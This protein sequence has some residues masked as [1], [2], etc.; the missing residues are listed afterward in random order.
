MNLI[1][2][3]II[4]FPSVPLL[5]LTATCSPEDAAKIDTVLERP[6]IKV[7]RNNHEGEG[8]VIIF[9]AT[10]QNCIDITDELR[11]AFDP[12]IIMSATS[13]FGMGINVSDV[14]LIIHTTLP[15]SNE[16][17]VQ[18]IERV[19]CLGQGSKAIIFYSRGEIRTLLAIIGGG[20]E[21]ARIQIRLRPQKLIPQY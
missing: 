15:L 13:A 18:E 8:R 3:N 14:T 11:K 2:L 20:Q 19:G 16:Q 12:S 1:F 17:Y 9:S 5:A 6:N 21:K 4:Y 7:I 10:I